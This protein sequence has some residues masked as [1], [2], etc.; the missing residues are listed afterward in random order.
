[1]VQR[2]GNEKENM[3]WQIA[4]C[5]CVCVCS[6]REGSHFS[7]PGVFN[8]MTAALNMDTCHIRRDPFFSCS[9]CP[10]FIFHIYYG[11]TTEVGYGSP[12]SR[13]SGGGGG[14]DEMEKVAGECGGYRHA[15]G[16]M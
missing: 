2:H 12:C 9:S 8:N 3:L 16:E 13:G 11:L 6:G 10:V 4:W 14:G 1:M 5:V 7:I 15:R